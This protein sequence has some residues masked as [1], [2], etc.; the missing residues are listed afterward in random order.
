MLRLAMMLTISLLIVP[1]VM[2]SSSLAAGPVQATPPTAAMRGA[3]AVLLGLQSR[4]AINALPKGEKRM[5]R[6]ENPQALSAHGLDGLAAGDEV[7][8]TRQEED[9]L[10]VRDPKSGKAVMLHAKDLAQ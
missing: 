2:T 5:M 3:Q 10:L 8:V 9:M 7:E 4:T 1:L 6:V